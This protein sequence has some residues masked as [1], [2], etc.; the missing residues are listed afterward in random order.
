[1]EKRTIPTPEALTDTSAVPAPLAEHLP[2]LLWDVDP[3]TI[4]PQAM[5]RTIVQRVIQR[6]SKEDWAA[7]LAYYGRPRV[8]E[9]VETVPY[10]SDAAIAAVCQ[11]FHIEKETLRCYQR[12]QS[13]PQTFNS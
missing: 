6:G 9:I 4:D 3:E 13:I 1:M 5:A 7:M 11:F 10:M 8:Q 2:T 12:K